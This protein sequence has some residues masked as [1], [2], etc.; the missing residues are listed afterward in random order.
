MTVPGQAESPTL[1]FP[2]ARPLPEGAGK[3]SLPS[4]FQ[5]FVTGTLETETGDVPLVS[6]KLFWRDKR[7]HYLVRWN[8]GR[9]HFT[10]E[11]G[12]YGLG[13]PTADSAVL[14]T[15]N[16]KLSFD[17]L[18]QTMTGRS[19]WILVLDTKGIN[20]WCAAGKGTFSTEELVDRIKASRLTDIVNHNRLIVPQLGAT[21]V[22][23]FDVKKYSGFSVVYGPV[24][25]QDLPV[26]IDSACIASPEMRLKKFPFRERLTLVPVEIM[27]AFKQGLPFIVAFLFLAGFAG[28]NSFLSNLKLHGIPLALAFL[29]GIASGTILC[30]LLLPWVPGRAFS[31]KGALCG[32]V[33]FI[34]FF[35]FSGLYA[36]DYSLLEKSSWPLITLAVSSWFGMSF[37]GASTYTS[38]NGV[39]KEML[40]AMPIQFFSLVCGISLWA[41]SLWFD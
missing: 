26:F 3:L 13:K 27:Q 15:A 20:V 31:V 35:G 11:P 12:L 7:G 2:M 28:D 23:A 4:V 18:R 25:L 9:D 17:T 40:R 30:P 10:V 6:S 8:I 14:V 36:M 41:A 19:C 37:T 38:L 21:G 1:I 33:L 24:M 29:T 16:Y 34:I 39:R 32:L 5:S 22:A